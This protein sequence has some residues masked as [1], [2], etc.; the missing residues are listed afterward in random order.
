MPKKWYFGLDL[1]DTSA[2]SYI[3]QGWAVAPKTGGGVVVEAEKTD[4]FKAAEAVHAARAEL[5]IAGPCCG[6]CGRPRVR[7][8]VILRDLLACWECAEK[9]RK[10]GK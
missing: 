10:R 5:A 2:Y 1:L 6:F 9:F 3:H 7:W 8:Q 4:G